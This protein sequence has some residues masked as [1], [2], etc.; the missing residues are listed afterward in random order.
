MQKKKVLGVRIEYSSSKFFL[1]YTDF[2]AKFIIAE[3]VPSKD[4]FSSP[5]LRESLAKFS[6]DN[7]EEKLLEKTFGQMYLTYNHLS[8]RAIWEGYWPFSFPAKRFLKKGIASDLEEIVI[9]RLEEK[10]P[11]LRKYKHIKR[12]LLHPRESQLKSRGI[13]PS[14]PYTPK[15]ALRKIRFKR[16]MALFKPKRPKPK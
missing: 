7:P 1:I 8:R 14:K 9:M 4:F 2:Q 11:K 3:D 6:K 15:E 10:F 5:E 16:A 13:D 12:Y